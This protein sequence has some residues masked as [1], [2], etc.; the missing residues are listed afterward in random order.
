MQNFITH[1]FDSIVELN[2]SLLIVCA[3][4]FLTIGV[5]KGCANNAAQ[6]KLHQQYM[7]SCVNKGVA[8]TDCAIGWKSS[9]TP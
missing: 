8:P 3:T 9:R 5:S 1:L 2:F 7:V 6:D 4:L